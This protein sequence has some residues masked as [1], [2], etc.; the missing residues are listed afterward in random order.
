M[1]RCLNVDEIV[2]LIAYELVGSGSKGT[3]VCLACCCKGFGDPVLDVLWATQTNLSPLFKCLPGDVREEGGSYMVPVSI[4]MRRILLFPQRLDLKDLQAL[5]DG[6]GMDSFSRVRSKNAKAQFPLRSENSVLEGLFRHETLHTQQ[7]L[8]PKSDNS[9]F[10]GSRGIVYSV[11]PIVPFPWNHLHLHRALF[12]PS[13]HIRV[14][15][16]DHK[17]ADVLPE[18]ATYRPLALAKRPDD[19]HSRF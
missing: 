14:R 18:P 5:S 8:T 12:S 2:R 13:P 7:P 19:H 6:D 17:S 4:P 16:N 1:H 11:H 3:A 9:R 10:V 15:F